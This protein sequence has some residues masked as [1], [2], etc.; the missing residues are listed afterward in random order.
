MVTAFNDNSVVANDN[1]WTLDRLN[2]ES[3]KQV[4][5]QKDGWEFVENS[6]T[7]SQTVTLTQT[8]DEVEQQE[9]NIYK[10]TFLT[11]AKWGATAA[12]LGLT[13]LYGPT[14]L[15]WGTYYGTSY[16]FG[17]LGIAGITGVSAATK[18]AILVADSPAAQT[19]LTAAGGLVAKYGVTA[20]VKVAEVVGSGALAGTK[21][22][23]NGL[24]SLGSYAYN[25]FWGSKPIVKEE[26]KTLTREELR[27][28]TLRAIEKRQNPQKLAGMAN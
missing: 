28:N 4:Q 21:Y 8:K 12:G 3:P 20:T 11:A 27:A 25:S 15:F 13:Y 9:G 7:R 16:A 22:A 19:A 6:M 18:A 17:K 10:D 5:A 26:E 2:R 24:W 23:A 1:I 14:A